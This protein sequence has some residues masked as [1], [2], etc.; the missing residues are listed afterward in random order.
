MPDPDRA[1]GTLNRLKALGVKVAIN[2]FATGYSS[3]AYLA[4]FP[5]DTVKLDRLARVKGLGCPYGQ[6]SLLGRPDPAE[7]L[8]AWLAARGRRC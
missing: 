6:G 7:R 5:V 2:D 8:E 1:V 4:R 3:L